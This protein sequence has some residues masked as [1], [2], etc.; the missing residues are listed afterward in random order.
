MTPTHHIDKMVFI[1]RVLVLF[2]INAQVKKKKGE[3]TN[4]PTLACL[5]VILMY[6][7][8]RPIALPPAIIKG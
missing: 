3:A 6:P 8:C 4:Q 5:Q 2:A 7:V 1:N